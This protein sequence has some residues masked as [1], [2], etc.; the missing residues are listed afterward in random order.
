MRLVIIESPFKADT[1]EGSIRNRLYARLC[2]HDCLVNRHE[3]PYASHLLYTQPNI[4]NDGIP[5]ERARGI[6][7]GLIW[8]KRAEA[9][10]VY[11]DLGITE[12]MKK[13][14]KRAEDD[15][16]I[17]EERKLPGEL[18]AI[19]EHPDP[20]LMGAYAQAVIA[21]D[22]IRAL[23]R[24][25]ITAKEKQKKVF[26][27]SPVRNVS[28]EIYER[29]S[30]YVAK[31]ERDDILVHWPIRDTKQDDPSGGY[32][33]CKTNFRAIL[34]ADEIHVWYDETS[35]GSKFDMGGV[36]MLTQMIGFRKTIVIPNQ[37]DAEKKDSAPKSFLKVMKHLTSKD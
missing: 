7:A 37:A 34:E 25:G 14:I 3:A 15:G 27:I 23:V 16:R 30:D 28:G 22:Y 31:L 26:F 6:E 11:T 10:A 36:F 29:N 17:V 5:E 24:R 35:S 2:Q 12:G 13:G 21:E 33:I 19:V 4:L 1:L 9:T 18:M 20:E 32:E 8:G